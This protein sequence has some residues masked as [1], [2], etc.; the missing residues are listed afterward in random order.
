MTAMM[1]ESDD[2]NDA[3]HGSAAPLSSSRIA[4]GI[5]DRR[6]VRGAGVVASNVSGVG[7]SG[8]GASAAGDSAH[9]DEARRR[10]EDLQADWAD[11]CIGLKKD[12]GQQLYNQWI[13][14]VELGPFLSLIHI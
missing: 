1:R 2:T 7:V 10:A 13:R 6:D 14:P 11:I 9:S 8:A 3:G 4:S 12:L 5:G